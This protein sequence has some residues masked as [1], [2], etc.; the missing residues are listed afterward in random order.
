MSEFS[1]HV[2]TINRLY[3]C[4]AEQLYCRAF[5]LHPENPTAIVWI[6]KRLL[7]ITDSE[8]AMKGY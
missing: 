8:K 1:E 2:N 4:C 7:I 3:R 6:F 5:T